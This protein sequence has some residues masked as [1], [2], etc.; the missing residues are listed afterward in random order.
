M[1]AAAGGSTDSIVSP[2]QHFGVIAECIDRGRMEDTFTD[3]KTGK[4]ITR[5][6][7]K[8]AFAIQV[9]EMTKPPE[10]SDWAPRNKVIWLNFNNTTSP[11]GHLYKYWKKITGQ[12]LKKGDDLDS[13]AAYGQGD[14]EQQ[15]PGVSV[16]IDVEQ[17]ETG[18]AYID[19]IRPDPENTHTLAPYEPWWKRN[20]A[21]EV[22]EE[23]VEA[24]ANAEKAEE[25][26]TLDDDIPF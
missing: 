5:W 8:G 7:H 26:E 25:L 3:K 18:R 15:R 17:S 10:D 23:P 13:V 12:I 19:Y 14:T 9:Q 21:D 24:K 22:E 20:Q 4:K 16:I 11:K 2:G 1:K 6:V